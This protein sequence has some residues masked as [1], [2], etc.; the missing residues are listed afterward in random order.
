MLNL[1]EDKIFS[2]VSA[3]YEFFLRYFKLLPLVTHF[4]QSKANWVEA[5]HLLKSEIYHR[6]HVP[7]LDA[8][9]KYI[10]VVKKLNNHLMKKALTSISID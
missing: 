3:C 1:Y 8:M 9:D 5:Q 10:E 6:T 4:N 2:D 7:M